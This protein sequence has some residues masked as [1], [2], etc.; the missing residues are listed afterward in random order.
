MQGFVNRGTGILNAKGRHGS[1]QNQLMNFKCLTIVLYA[2]P[3]DIY[4]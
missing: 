3:C 4:N 1:F 2:Y